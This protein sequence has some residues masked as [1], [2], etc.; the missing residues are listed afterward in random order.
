MLGWKILSNEI[1]LIY[2]FKGQINTLEVKFDDKIS[3]II[4]NNHVLTRAKTFFKADLPNI[5]DSLEM[6]KYEVRRF[7]DYDIK[8]NRDLV[9][10]P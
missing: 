8:I 5:D 10:K 7:K 6:L 3:Q 9:T 1:A 2:S 4:E